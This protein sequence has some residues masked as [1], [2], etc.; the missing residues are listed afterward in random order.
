MRRHM[1]WSLA[2][3]V[4]LT[5]ASTG[6]GQQ[7]RIYRI[8]VLSIGHLGGPQLDGFRNGLKESGYVE[9]KNLLLD[10]P[11]K[12][13]YDELR[14]IAKTYKEKNFDVIVTFGGTTSL[15]AK[16]ETQ[17]IP[18]V[19]IGVSDPLAIGLVKSL[20]DPGANV[21]GVAN[22]TDIDVDGKRLEVF[23]E[24]A[25]TMRR[26]AVLYNA[27][28][29]NPV[30]LKRL[31]VVHK[32]APNFG[33]KVAEKPIKSTSDVESAVSSMSRDVRDGIF[34]ICSSLFHDS[35]KTIVAVS[36]EKRI[37]LMGCRA[38][39]VKDNGALVSYESDTYRLGH[40]G[41]WYVE[42]ILK[43][44]KPQDLPVELPAYFELVINLKT[45]KQIGLTIPPNVLARADRVIK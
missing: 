34:I 28:G 20:A 21:T 40:R 26:L 13:N 32:V 7:E 11:A 15:M 43:G 5:A 36:I 38:S 18:I 17:E 12:K 35:I 3:A 8:G 22:R 45:A 14:P 25:P 44:K 33:L 9:G 4:I 23:K 6:H 29:D 2:A 24:I 41:A 37:P 30:H 16:E 42:R 27:R 10:I 1:V 39:D 31:E 19:F